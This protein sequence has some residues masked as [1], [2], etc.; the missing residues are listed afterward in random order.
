M[1]FIH[2][3][4][5]AL[6]I[7]CNWSQL[8]NTSM[9]IPL[10]KMPTHLE[11]SVEQYKTCRM[12]A[13]NCKPCKLCMSC[14]LTQHIKHYIAKTQLEKTQGC[15][16]TVDVRPTEDEVTLCWRDERRNSGSDAGFFRV[17]HVMCPYL[18]ALSPDD[19]SLNA[20]CVVLPLLAFSPF[21]WWTRVWCGT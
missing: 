4:H 14:Y 19:L 16:R 8:A 18:R 6:Q 17:K 10:E 12:Y 21:V 5:S 20:H 7:T 1:N 11:Q 3:R 9:K 15:Y 13:N 2:P